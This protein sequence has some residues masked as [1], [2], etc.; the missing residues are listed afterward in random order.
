MNGIGC[1]INSTNYNF[2]HIISLTLHKKISI[3]E[4]TM[5]TQSLKDTLLAFLLLT[6]VISILAFASYKLALELWCIAYGLI[7]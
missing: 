4:D 6:P 7:Y 2:G 3:L 5:N 1:V